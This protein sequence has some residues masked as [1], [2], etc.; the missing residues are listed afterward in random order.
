M[1]KIEIRYIFFVNG[2]SYYTVYFWHNKNT[3]FSVHKCWI[4]PQL[5]NIMNFL[6]KIQSWQNFKLTWTLLTSSK[7][8]TNISRPK[9]DESRCKSRKTI[10]EPFKNPELQ[11]LWTWFD[12]TL[13]TSIYIYKLHCHLQIGI[14][15]WIIKYIAKN[16]SCSSLIYF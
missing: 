5:I 12:P 15:C 16:G 3:Y 13:N 11:T 1:D 6:K 9:H 14:A 10:L 4:E 8:N 2:S 7:K